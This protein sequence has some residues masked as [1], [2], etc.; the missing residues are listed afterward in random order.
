MDHHDLDAG[1]CGAGCLVGMGLYRPAK[2][3]VGPVCSGG[4]LVCRCNGVALAS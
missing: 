4:Y 3:Y 1:E 2:D